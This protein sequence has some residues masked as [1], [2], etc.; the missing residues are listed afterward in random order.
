[1][2][3]RLLSAALLTGMVAVTPAAAQ[4]YDGRARLYRLEPES[5]FQR[6]CFPPC[7]CPYLETARLSGSFRLGLAS[8]GNVFDFYDVSRVRFKVV[9][10]STDALPITGAGQYKVSTVAGIQ[11]MWLDLAVGADPPERFDSGE[12]ALQVAFPRIA[13][14]VSINGGYCHDTVLD[15][16]ARPTMRLHANA[17]DL[18]WEEESNDSAPWDVVYGDLGVLRSSGGDFA[19][20][21]MACLARDY[22]GSALAFDFDPAPGQGFWFLARRFD[23]T[24]ADGAPEQTGDPDAGIA[25]SSAACR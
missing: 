21:S 5:T 8:V 24:F 20:A 2:R 15:L 25:N 19:A 17:A 7:L 16:R 10:S 3:T 4:F 22:W 13:V 11:Q 23:G 9:R 14:T 12:V 18:S 1:M 6:G